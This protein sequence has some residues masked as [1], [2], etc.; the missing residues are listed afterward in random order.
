MNRIGFALALGLGFAASS[1]S[2]QELGP[3][4]GLGLGLHSAT[5]TGLSY[6]QP[7]GNTAGAGISNANFRLG[8]NVA[9]S[10]GYRWNDEMRLEME[11]SHRSVGL[12]NIAAEDAAGKQ[13]AVSIMANV[14][15]NIGQG[16]NFYPYVGGGVGLANNSWNDVKTPTSPI[17]DDSDKKLQWQVIVGLEMP[18]NPKT[19]WF[20]DYRY[21]NSVDNEFNTIPANARVVGVDLSSHNLMVGVRHRF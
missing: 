4:V 3:Y 2:A 10:V 8:F 19:N 17:Y 18:I 16:T 6:E 7:P 21:I 20:A 12:D 13:R 1:V 5:A 14:L 15:F 9:A 11:L